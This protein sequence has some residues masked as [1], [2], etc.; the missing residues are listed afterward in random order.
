MDNTERLNYFKRIIREAYASYTPI[1]TDEEQREMEQLYPTTT[2][3]LNTQNILPTME[4]SYP[5][6][7]NLLNTRNILPT[8]MELLSQSMNIPISQMT[9]IQ[10]D[11]DLE[12][13]E[14]DIE[15]NSQQNVDVGYRTT[16]SIS[17]DGQGTL[18]YDYYIPIGQH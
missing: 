18:T 12:N 7:T 16:L 6:T 3:S 2:S 10:D 13:A 8:I 17:N 14:T 1:N 5:T 9:D 11:E 4:Q 15:D